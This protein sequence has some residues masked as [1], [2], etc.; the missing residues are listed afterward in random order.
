MKSI[1]KA[2]AAIMAVV[3]VFCLVVAYWDKICETFA[4]V[5]EKSRDVKA[6]CPLC[7]SEYEDYAD[8]E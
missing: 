1:L 3:A 6:H 8:W 5:V 7:S 4:R 2:V